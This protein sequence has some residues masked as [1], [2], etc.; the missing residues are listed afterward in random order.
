MILSNDYRHPASVVHEA[1]TIDAISGGRFDQVA[2]V[3]RNRL[4]RMQYRPR[5]IHGFLVQAGLTLEPE[6]P[7]DARPWH[8]PGSMAGVM[9]RPAPV[10]YGLGRVRRARGIPEPEARPEAPTCWLRK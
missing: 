9:A 10:R 1:A 2:V 4:R 8:C 6:P 7:V 5:L 3:I